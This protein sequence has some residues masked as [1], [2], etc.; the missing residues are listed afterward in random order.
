MRLADILHRFASA[1]LRPAPLPEPVESDGRDLVTFIPFDDD[2]DD[3][4]RGD[5]G[6]RAFLDRMNT[7]MRNKPNA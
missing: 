2:D 5:A 1:L 7:A 3:G 6:G 4:F